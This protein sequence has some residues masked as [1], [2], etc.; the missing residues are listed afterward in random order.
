MWIPLRLVTAAT[1]A[2][3][4]DRAAW[5]S[6]M[7]LIGAMAMERAMPAEDVE[8]MVL[9]RGVMVPG[10]EMPTVSTVER[11]GERFVAWVERQGVTL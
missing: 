8:R 1:E 5:R 11:G 7:R 10:A 2:E 4:P 9:L 3:I 6:T